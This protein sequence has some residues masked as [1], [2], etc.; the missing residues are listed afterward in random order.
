MKVKDTMIQ[1]MKDTLNFNQKAFSE[2]SNTQTT[3]KT[4]TV[5]KSTDKLTIEEDELKLAQM[6]AKTE[7]FTNKVWEELNIRLGFPD[8][9]KE[10]NIYETLFL[11][12]LAIQTFIRKLIQSFQDDTMIFI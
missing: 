5:E 12:Q 1:E 7:L 11:I 6:N 9:E 2:S 8:N 10:K 4:T 3:A